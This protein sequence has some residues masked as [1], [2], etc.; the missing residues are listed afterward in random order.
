[1]KKALG[2]WPDKTTTNIQ[3]FWQYVLAKM[4]PSMGNPSESH[5]FQMSMFMCFINLYHEQNI[6]CKGHHSIS[7]I[8]WV[9]CTCITFWN[10]DFLTVGKKWFLYIFEVWIKELYWIG[11]YTINFND[12][13]CNFKALLNIFL[14]IGMDKMWYQR[15]LLFFLL[16][17]FFS[18]FCLATLARFSHRRL[19]M[20]TSPILIVHVLDL[21]LPT[22]PYKRR[23]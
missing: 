2:F 14:H 16:F 11:I 9:T 15:G 1:M 5:F 22:L 18:E 6:L 19:H 13:R 12:I 7:N 20:L 10:V 8:L 4:W 3:T 21:H 23:L 17:P